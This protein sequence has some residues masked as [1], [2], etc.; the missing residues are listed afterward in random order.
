[1]VSVDL[2]D[3]VLN[4]KGWTTRHKAFNLGGHC[5][6]AQLDTEHAT[7]DDRRPDHKFEFSYDE[8]DGVNVVSRIASAEVPLMAV[9]FPPASPMTP[10]IVY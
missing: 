1:M 2:R 8:I 10:I 5:T 9:N 3:R 7:L 6:Y 4:V